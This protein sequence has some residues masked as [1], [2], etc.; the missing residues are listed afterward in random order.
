VQLDLF[1]PYKE[2]YEFKVIVTN[3]RVCAR[4][5]VAFHEGRGS[6]EGVLAELKSGCFIDCIPARRLNGNQ[7]YLLG[8]L[9]AHNLMR[10]L[11]LRAGVQMRKRTLKRTS[12]WLF[13]K[14]DTIRKTTIQ[15]AGKLT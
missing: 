3:K 4:A 2:G 11:Q 6:Q 8:G 7:T 15:R 9:F 1:V 13:E 12:L 14:V 10:E 5:V